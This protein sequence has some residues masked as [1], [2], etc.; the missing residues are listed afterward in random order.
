MTQP[1]AVWV[2][3][4]TPIWLTLVCERWCQGGERLYHR[5][6]MLALDEIEEKRRG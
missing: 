4:Q 5:A 2:N 1:L 6:V 3:G